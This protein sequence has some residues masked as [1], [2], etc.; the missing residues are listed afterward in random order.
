MLVKCTLNTFMSDVRYRGT[1]IQCGTYLY[2]TTRVSCLVRRMSGVGPAGGR[3][4]PANILTLVQYRAKTN[5]L[6]DQGLG[7]RLA[8]PAVL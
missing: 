5:F 3:Y 4:D 2:K 6:L 1:D 7:T 8:C